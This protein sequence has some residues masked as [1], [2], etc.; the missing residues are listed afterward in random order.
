L[1]CII[2]TFLIVKRR[3][4]RRRK[5]QRERDEASGVGSADVAQI[6]EDDQLLATSEEPKPEPRGPFNEQEAREKVANEK[7]MAKLHC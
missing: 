2:I 1:I 7:I 3:D 5:K 6:A 4:A